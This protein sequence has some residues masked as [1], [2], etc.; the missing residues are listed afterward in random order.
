MATKASTHR[1]DPEVQVSLDHLSKVLRQ[2]KNQLINE[3]V[4]LYV[5]QRSKE[6][7]EELENTL[8]TLRSYTQT[9]PAFE[10]SIL[11]VAESEAQYGKSD[12]VEGEVIVSKGKVRT[13]IQD[14]LRA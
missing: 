8:K 1:L 7:V 2:P 6:V 13:E 10:K 9:D 3:A 14:I 5:S 11:A 12:P 4:K